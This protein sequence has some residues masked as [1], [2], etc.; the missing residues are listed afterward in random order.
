M[1]LQHH[2][3]RLAVQVGQVF[4]GGNNPV[5]IQS[6]TNTDTANV[7]ET[8]KQIIELWQA[9]SEIVRVTVNN[10]AA[11]KAV[12]EI[13]N[14]LLS[15]NCNVPIVGDFHFNGHKLLKSYQDCAQALAKYRIN[16][17]NVGKGSKK[18]AQFAE[19]IQFAIEYNKPIRIGVNWGSLDQELLAKM[20]DENNQLNYPLDAKSVMREALI[21]SALTSAEQ[22]VEIGLPKD[23][24]ILSC[25]TSDTQ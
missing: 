18:D 24:I 21:V 22:A 6:M 10:E 14:A 2:R 25:K 11:A 13:Y 17:G 1:T 9:G 4:V 20:M 16:P 3:N 8:V 19:M 5:V 23:K 7:H 12:P 15:K